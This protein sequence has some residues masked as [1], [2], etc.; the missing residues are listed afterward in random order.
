MLVGQA[1][2]TKSAKFYFDF[3][4]MIPH[5]V[6]AYYSS[7]AHGSY[8]MSFY[9]IKTVQISYVYVCIDKSVTKMC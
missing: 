6:L 3:Q 8:W 5:L 9:Q 2:E 1:E 4:I 7:C